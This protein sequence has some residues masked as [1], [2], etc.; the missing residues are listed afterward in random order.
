MEV[1][2]ESNRPHPKTGLQARKY[3]EI[4]SESLCSVSVVAG[5]KTQ[6]LVAVTHFNGEF[7]HTPPSYVYSMHK[8]AS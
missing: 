4:L 2:Q 1:M 5:H 8:D 7:H 6:V 3:Q